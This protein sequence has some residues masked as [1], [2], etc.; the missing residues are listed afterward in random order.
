[1]LIPGGCFDSTDEGVC[2]GTAPWAL[3]LSM[4]SLA[5][6][7]QLHVKYANFSSPWFCPAEAQL[8]I[9]AGYCRGA[10][11]LY[12]PRACHTIEGLAVADLLSASTDE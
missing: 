9:P 10:E 8:W 4:A 12:P 11:I 7:R 2:E 3:P 6:P 1:M 5:S